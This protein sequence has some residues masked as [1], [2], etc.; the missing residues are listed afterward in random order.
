MDVRKEVQSTQRQHTGLHH[1]KWSGQYYYLISHIIH[2]VMPHQCHH[3]IKCRLLWLQHLCIMQSNVKVY[4]CF[5]NSFVRLNILVLIWRLINWSYLCCPFLY[6]S[7]C[8]SSCLSFIASLYFWF[9]WES[10]IT[11]CGAE[12]QN[13]SSLIAQIYTH[14]TLGGMQREQQKTKESRFV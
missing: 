10:F 6:L 5:L 9:L 4:F 1:R 3:W 14:S 12:Q 2:W 13:K 8:C 11:F 7:H